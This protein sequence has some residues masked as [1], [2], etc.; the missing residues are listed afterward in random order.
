MYLS[1][2]NS[3]NISTNISEKNI[4]ATK[5]KKEYGQHFLKN[6]HVISKIVSAIGSNYH[7]I[8]EIGPG[9]GALTQKLLEFFSVKAIEIDIDCITV[10]KEKFADNEK[11]EIIYKNVLEYDFSLNASS[12]VVGNLPYNIS[13]KIIEKILNENVELA[14]FMLQKEVAYRILE[15]DSPLGICVHARYFVKKVINVEAKDFSPKPKVESQVIKL[16]KHDLFDQVNIDKLY[17][18][19]KAM[20]TNRRKKL[21]HLKKTNPQL[22]P[23]LL[24]LR[25]FKKLVAMS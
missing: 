9:H 1:K 15:A 11:L 21:M 22:I 2:P 18:I 20:F 25:S 19:T 5:P 23:L 14:V 10:L 13:T 6:K 12:C 4:I 7:A 16:I 3:K 17:K 24:S 8:I